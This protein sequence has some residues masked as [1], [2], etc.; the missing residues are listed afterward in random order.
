MTEQNDLLQNIT[1]LLAAQ[2]SAQGPQ[3]GL[4][5]WAQPQPAATLVQ[6]VGVPVKI[7]RGRGNLKIMLWLP[8]DA[9]SSPAALNA[10]L[11]RLEAVGIPLDVWEPQSSGWGG[12]SRN[13]S[14]R[15]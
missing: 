9:A 4:S 15:R 7:A 6:G 1:N 5:G 2:Q 10:A 14:W 8:A 11:D 12:A 13:N 3:S